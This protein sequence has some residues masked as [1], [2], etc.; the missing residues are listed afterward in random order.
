MSPSSDADARH[1][2]LH[3]VAGADEVVQPT[4]VNGSEFQVN[5]PARDIHLPQRANIPC[6]T[7]P[8]VRLTALDRYWTSNL[9][10]H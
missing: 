6:R 10:Q 3:G 5:G 9:L 1:Q 4:P 7:E 2:L 8:P